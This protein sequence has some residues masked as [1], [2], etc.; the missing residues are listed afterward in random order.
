MLAPIT[1][2]GELLNLLSTI[3]INVFH[4][5]SIYIFMQVLADSISLPCKLVKGSHYT[6]T[7]D[8][9]LNIIKL[10]NDRCQL[11]FF[12]LQCVCGIVCFQVTWPLEYIN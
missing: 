10:E 9:A 1:V 2:N 6:G 11:E 3:F 8:D 5:I 4:I 12:F 7:E